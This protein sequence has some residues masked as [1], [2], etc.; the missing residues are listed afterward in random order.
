MEPWLELRNAI[1]RQAADDY[2]NAY[3]RLKK[4]PNDLLAYSTYCECKQFLKS[5]T[6]FDGTYIMKTIE[7]NVDNSLRKRG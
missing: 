7:E 3:R 1:V 2:K 6:V 4:D 5:L